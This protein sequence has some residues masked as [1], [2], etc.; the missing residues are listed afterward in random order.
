MADYL[1]NKTD[2]SVPPVVVP[3]KRINNTSLDVTLLGKIK[4]EYGEALNEDLLNI[5]E[6]FACPQMTTGTVRPDTSLTSKNQ[7]QNP[8]DGQF[9]YNTTDGLMYHWA[10][11]A[12]TPIASRE[13]Y[14]ANWGQVVNGQQLPKPVSPITGRIFNYNECIWTVSPAI[15]LGKVAYLNCNTDDNATVNM[16][17]RY[18][19]SSEFFNGTVNYLIIGLGDNA[20]SGPYP[21]F[22]S[23]SVTPSVTPTIS[24][25][26]TPTPTMTVTPSVTLS[27]TAVPTPTPTPTMSATPPPSGTPTRTPVVS[28]T[29]VPSSTPAPTSTPTSTPTPTPRPALST[30]IVGGDYS[31]ASQVNTGAQVAAAV[32][33]RNNGTVAYSQNRGGST[34]KTQW[35]LSGNPG[36]YELAFISS[37]EAQF[38]GSSSFSTP[39]GANTHGNGNVWYDLGAN[40][41]SWSVSSTRD[42][43]NMYVNF[44]IR[45]KN[46]SSQIVTGTISLY[47]QAGTPV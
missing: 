45:R 46:D 41:L 44:Q 39:A 4:R 27:K 40:G 29:P 19:G 2:S 1:I 30:I 9:W 18:S 24:L 15:V 31:A 36:D 5:L 3:E 23:P 34:N 22:P 14:A 47:G 12:W 20:T 42:V 16:R 32:G 38:P 13:G 10:G 28:S 7:L 8:T 37:W 25:S 26:P 11:T 35:L 21:A 17:Y 43:V 33:F 6:N